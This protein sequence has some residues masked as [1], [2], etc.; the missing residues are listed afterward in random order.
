MGHWGD[1]CLEAK[2]F[3]GTFFCPNKIFDIWAKTELST[4]FFGEQNN[5][6][7]QIHN[8]CTVPKTLVDTTKVWFFEFN[9]SFLEQNN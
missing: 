6:V 7:Q 3:V 1:C 4:I 5:L 8:F 2:N 9:Q